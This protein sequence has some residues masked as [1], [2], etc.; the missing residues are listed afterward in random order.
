VEVSGLN[1][2]ESTLVP[3]EWEDGW[4]ME[5]VWTFGKEKNVFPMPGF[6]PHTIQL[7]EA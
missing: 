2:R 6:E 3:I 5:H 7:V 1:V 4:A